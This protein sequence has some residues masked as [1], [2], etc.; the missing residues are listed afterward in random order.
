MEHPNPRAQLEMI[1]R[2]LCR[3][4]GFRGFTPGF[5]L[6]VGAAATAATAVITPIGA[7]RAVSAVAVAWVVVGG[8][9]AMV[10]FFTV[11]VPALRSSSTIKREAAQATGI[12]MAFPLGTGLAVTF[13]VLAHHPTAIPLLPS[14]WLALFGL[15]VAALAGLIRERVEYAAVLYLAAAGGAYFL[16]PETPALFSLAVGVPFSVGHLV[17]AW[18]LRRTTRNPRQGTHG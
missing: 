6:T 10:V 4:T 15:G 1:Y 8:I 17:T 16:R 18:L 9:I 3:S 5:L 12:Q 7:G 2:Q 11:L 14:I 13:A